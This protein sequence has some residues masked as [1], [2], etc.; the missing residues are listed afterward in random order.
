MNATT[1]AGLKRA[2]NAAWDSLPQILLS[3][4]LALAVF[5]GGLW[6]GHRDLVAVV[7]GVSH[8]Q[9]PAGLCARIEQCPVC[10]KLQALAT[11]AKAAIAEARHHIDSHNAESLEWKRRIVDLELKVYNMAAQP[12]ARPDPF[13][14]AMGRMLEERIKDLEQKQ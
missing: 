11:D 13:T 10:D 12:T 14:G 3:S 4:V 2:I 9:Q 5:L 6:I 7:D 8:N 1:S